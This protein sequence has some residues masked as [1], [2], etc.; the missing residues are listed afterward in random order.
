MEIFIVWFALSIVAG[1]IAGN[2]QR[3]GFGFFLLSLLLSPLIGIIAALVAK[4][5]IDKLE[6]QQLNE[7]KS[8][9][10]PFCAELIKK[11]A[12]VCRYCGKEL[13][14]SKIEENL[15]TN[16]KHKSNYSDGFYC[17]IRKGAPTCKTW[18]EM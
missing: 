18:E 3:S 2:K 8:K 15:C 14:P 4:P 16:C 10:C 9:K 13:S 17:E 5:N 7:G 6:K 1:V 12:I 11:E